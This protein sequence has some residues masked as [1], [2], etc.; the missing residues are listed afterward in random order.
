M[1]STISFQ[2]GKE[3]HYKSEAYS[4]AKIRNTK[5]QYA[6]TAAISDVVVQVKDDTFTIKVSD[7]MLAMLFPR[8]F[9]IERH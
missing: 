7:S 3:Y 5:P 2:S 1:V 9:L 4:Y 6:G 8:E